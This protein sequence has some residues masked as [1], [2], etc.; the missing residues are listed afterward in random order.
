MIKFYPKRYNKNKILIFPIENVAKL[1]FNLKKKTTLQVYFHHKR[2]Y[3]LNG[4]K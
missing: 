2:S 4:I 1:Q 3:I